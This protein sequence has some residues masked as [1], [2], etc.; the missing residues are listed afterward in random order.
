[1]STT[2]DISLLMKS[3]CGVRS[4]VMLKPADREIESGDENTGCQSNTIFLSDEDSFSSSLHA[5]RIS[6]Q[7]YAI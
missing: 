3:D 1:M 6:L 2:F 5:V 7:P 4:V